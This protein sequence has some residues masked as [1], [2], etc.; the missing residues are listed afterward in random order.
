MD[1]VIA[2]PT[3][4]VVI[5]AIPATKVSE[6]TFSVPIPV[7]VVMPASIGETEIYLPKLMVVAAPTSASS[8]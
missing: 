2:V 5:V 1:A 4:R 3:F 6:V 8:S 7:I